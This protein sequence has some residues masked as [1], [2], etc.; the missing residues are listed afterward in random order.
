MLDNRGSNV[1]Q[2]GKPDAMSLGGA[3]QFSS[4][5]VT[6]RKVFEYSCIKI[7]FSDII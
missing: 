5:M 7:D 4:F 3:G 6:S 1:V 2:V